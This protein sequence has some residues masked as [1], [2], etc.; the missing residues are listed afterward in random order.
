MILKNRI[1]KRGII[2]NKGR[3]ERKVFKYSYFS[4]LMVFAYSM[5][6][7]HQYGYFDIER[8][9]YG[10]V[11]Y[12]ALAVIGIVMSAFPEFVA[13]TMKKD[14]GSPVND[15]KVRMS[16]K[17]GMLIFVVCAVQI[18]SRWM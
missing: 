16:K 9:V 6:N 18:A 15:E 14:M 1:L 12:S 11:G 10:T 8:A 4:L 2:V 7:S 17:T 5:Y 3:I 13:K